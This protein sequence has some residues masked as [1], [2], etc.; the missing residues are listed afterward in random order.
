[1]Q[2]CLP[3]H[4]LSGLDYRRLHSEPVNE[5]NR[6][7]TPVEGLACLAKRQTRALCGI[8]D[9]LDQRRTICIE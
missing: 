4:K 5:R 7:V 1:M 3:E 9:V 8:L 2:R 6:D